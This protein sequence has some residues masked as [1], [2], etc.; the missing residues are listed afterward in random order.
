MSSQ[1]ICSVAKVLSTTQVVISKGSISGLKDGM[2]FL[3]YQL[4]D[5]DITDPQTGENLGK[6]EIVKGTGKITHVQEKIA[7]V[8]SDMFRRVP[9]KRIIKRTENLWK[10]FPF[11]PSETI[12]EIPSEAPERLAFNDVKEGDFAKQIP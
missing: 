8:E 10:T 1:F 6:L 12:E 3:I 5:Y 11:N 4:S 2:R 7:I 9:P